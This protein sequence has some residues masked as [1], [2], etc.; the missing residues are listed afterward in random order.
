MIYKKINSS[1]YSVRNNSNLNLHMDGTT[2]YM[3]WA[4]A[5]AEGEIGY[6]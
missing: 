2:N 1:S 4:L 5:E 6:P 3:F